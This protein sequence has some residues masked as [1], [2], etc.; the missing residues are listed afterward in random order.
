MKNFFAVIPARSGSK[1]ILG[2]NFLPLGGR[3][4]IDFTI[5]HALQM[6]DLCDVVISTNNS[7]FSRDFSNE[8]QMRPKSMITNLNPI[9]EISEGIFLHNRSEELSQDHT[10]IMDVITEVRSVLRKS[11]RQYEGC[12]LLQPTVPFRS[13]DDLQNVR[14]Y[15]EKEASP[16][17]SFVT[18]KR[19]LDGH[20]ARMYQETEKSI[21]SN[22]GFFPEFAQSRRQD[23]PTLFLRDGCYYFIGSRLIDEKVQVSATPSGLIRSFPW[24]MNLDEVSDYILAEAIL[25]RYPEVDMQREGS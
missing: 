8:F 25:E 6:R 2:K 19:V 7:E 3:R 22:V 14:N 10:P 12:L 5:M 9:E 18:F 24:T 11:G 4:V 1:G 13:R 17:S 23:L 21:F 15:L 16:E 20:P